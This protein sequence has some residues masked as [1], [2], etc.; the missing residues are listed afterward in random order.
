LAPRPDIEEAIGVAEKHLKVVE[1]AEAVRTTPAFDPISLPPVDSIALESVLGRTV[2]DLDKAA[3]NKVRAHFDRLGEGGEQWVADGMNRTTPVGDQAEL[4]RCPFCDQDLRGSVLFDLYRAYFSTEYDHLKQDIANWLST[5]N[6]SLGGDEMAA[7]QGAVHTAEDGRRFW[8]SLCTVPEATIDTKRL[9]T[10][11]QEARETVLAALR[12]KQA[13]PL[14][15]IRLETEACAK[16]TEFE[17][18]AKEVVAANSALQAANTTIAQVKADADR[19]DVAQA[20]SEL[21]RLKAIKA[22]FSAEI[23][24]LCKA[25]LEE[26]KAK[27]ETERAKQDARRALDQHR[28]RVFPAYQEGINRH[29]ERFNAGFRIKGVEATNPSG[30]PSCTYHIVINNEMVRLDAAGKATATPSFKNTLSSGDRSTLALAFFFASL[31]QDPNLAQ[32]VVVIDDPVTSLDDHREISTVQEIRSL[33]GRI[34]QVIV[35]SHDKAFLCRLWQHADQGSSAALELSR[36]P[37]GS[38]IARW[39]VNEVSFTEYDR[40]HAVLRDYCSATINDRRDV[41]QSLRFVLEGFLR[42]AYPEHFPPGALWKHFREKVR[43]SLTTS[44]PIMTAS[45]FGELTNL[46]EYAS[47]FLH[48]TNP[49]WET[50]LRNIND[51]ELLQFV[52]RTLNFVKPHY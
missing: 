2:A 28:G 23:A 12:A 45:D 32:W 36:A 17:S 8:A 4:R 44:A 16:I 15:Q 5:I 22:R 1:N 10:V 35:L 24:P 20:T 30:H 41:A 18:L 46:F 26:K 29:L 42:V 9:S 6:R 33:V 47:R 13:S 34:T 51:G 21:A 25:Y 48:D 39:N 14:D 31:D 19:G 11:W 50:D 27:R 7:F 40:R 49:A 38:A 52:R 3:V 43:Q 37:S